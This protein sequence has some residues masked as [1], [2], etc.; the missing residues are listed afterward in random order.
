MTLLDYALARVLV[1]AFRACETSIGNS[2]LAE[3]SRWMITLLANS[4]F[5]YHPRPRGSCTPT[6]D[7][8]RQLVAA[9]RQ[10]N[11]DPKPPRF[12]FSIFVMS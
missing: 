9:L 1:R 7:H 4:K 6:L 10:P 5:E 3:R 12:G 8:L 11:L 2:P